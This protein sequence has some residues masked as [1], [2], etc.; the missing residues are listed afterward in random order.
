MQELLSSW[1]QFVFSFWRNFS[2]YWA[3]VDLLWNVNTKIYER[4]SRA[5]NIS[6]GCWFRFAVLRTSASLFVSWMNSD[7][8]RHRQPSLYNSRHCT[9]KSDTKRAQNCERIWHKSRFHDKYFDDFTFFEAF[10]IIPLNSWHRKIIHNPNL[11]VWENRARILNWQV[12]NSISL[13]GIFCFVS[14]LA[15]KWKGLLYHFICCDGS[16]AK[17]KYQCLQLLHF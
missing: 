4:W 5:I 8:F 15:Q 14:W 17:H 7:C 16:Y 2:S 6:D 1:T 12:L 13:D 10:L 9:N 11:F 3:R